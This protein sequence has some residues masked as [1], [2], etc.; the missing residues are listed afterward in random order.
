LNGVFDFTLSYEAAS[1]ESDITSI[2]MTALTKALDKQL[3]LKL[4][5]GRGQVDTLVTDR[6]QRPTPN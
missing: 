6:V 4:I 5:R 2:D 1:S 3:G